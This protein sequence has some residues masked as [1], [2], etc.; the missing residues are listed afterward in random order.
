MEKEKS[1][2]ELLNDATSISAEREQEIRKNA[3]KKANEIL[4][5]ITESYNN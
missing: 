3:I 5:E 4:N 1:L 2:D